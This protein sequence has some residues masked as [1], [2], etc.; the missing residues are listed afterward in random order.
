VVRL[1]SLNRRPYF[2]TR[3]RLGKNKNMEPETKLDSADEGKQQFTPP[4]NQKLAVIDKWQA[5]SSLSSKRRPHF[6][7]R[8]LSY[9]E[10]NMTMVPDG[11][12][13]LEMT[14]LA[15]AI[16]KLLPCPRSIPLLFNSWD[17][18]IPALLVSEKSGR[19]RRFLTSSVY[20]KQMNKG[21]VNMKKH[22][23]AERASSMI[24]AC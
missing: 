12:P 24:H 20:Y 1:L 18:E 17:G 8:K 10:K 9:N 6:K 3:A 16:I 11:T 22:D 21:K 7:T 4:T 5:D 14:V 19:S 15:K 13:K 2:K 23:S